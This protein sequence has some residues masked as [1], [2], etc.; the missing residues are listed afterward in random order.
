MIL[1]SVIFLFFIRKELFLI[2]QRLKKYIKM[3]S[4]P[5][6]VVLGQNIQTL[7]NSN[8]FDICELSKNIEYNREAISKLL[9]GKQNIKLNT[10]LKICKFFNVSV[11]SLFD[12]NFDNYFS[13]ESNEYIVV[14][15]IKLFFTNLQ[16]IKETNKI[17]LS[18]RFIDPATLSKIKHGQIKNPTINTL[19]SIANDYSTNLKALFSIKKE[20]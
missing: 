19:T 11:S 13:A 10:L 7:V 14:D 8:D 16:E 17:P 9:V 6:L 15:Y 4:N 5:E 18:Q 3:K 12:R 1:R 2:I 20:D